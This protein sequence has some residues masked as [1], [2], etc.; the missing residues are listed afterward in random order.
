LSSFVNTILQ[1]KRYGIYAVILLSVVLRMFQLGTESLWVDEGYSLRDAAGRF[2]LMDIRPLYFAML[3]FWGM[4]GESEA[5]LR[6]PATMDIPAAGY[7]VI[8]NSGSEDRLIGAATD[9]A[10]QVEMHQTAA[11]GGM[12]Q[13][14][15]VKFIAI[16]AGGQAEL[17][18][19][20]YHLMLIGLKRALKAGEQATLN[21]TFEKAGLLFVA[22]QV[23]E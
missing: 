7:L 6:M 2:R 14:A 12:M 11:S 10:A 5:W 15:P 17:K 21:L 22:A 16:P 4:L 20:G 18:P 1:N 3:H 13:M 19:G 9:L 23:R 8:R